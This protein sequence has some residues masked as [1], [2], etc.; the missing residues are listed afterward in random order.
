MRVNGWMCGI[1]GAVAGVVGCA[2]AGA[3][4]VAAGRVQQ[5]AQAVAAECASVYGKPAACV[6]VACDKRYQGFLGTWS[7]KFHAYVR[8]LSRPGHAV[9][10]PYAESVAYAATDCLRNTGNGDVSIVGRE[11]NRYPRFGKLPAKVE[12]NL[13]ITGRHADGSPYLRSV[14]KEG[15]CDYK[16]VFR[17][18]AAEMSIWRMRLSAGH[19]QPSMTFTTLDAGDP[20]AAPARRRNVTITMQIGPDSEPYWRGVLAYGW[21]AHHGRRAS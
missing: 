1:L 17:D 2:G 18:V 19:G 14:R 15:S 4:P 7:G 11:T 8:G 12:H 16:L 13:L 3:A 21:H 10:R 6:R 9:F 20:N 5:P